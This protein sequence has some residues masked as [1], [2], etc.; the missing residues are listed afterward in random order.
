MLDNPIHGTLPGKF[1]KLILLLLHSLD[2]FLC[3]RDFMN[4]N[5]QV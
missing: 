1:V 5:L 4:A 3:T 2:V